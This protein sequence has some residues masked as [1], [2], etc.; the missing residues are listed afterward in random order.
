MTQES[1]L[2]TGP[3]SWVLSLEWCSEIFFVA[4]IPSAPFRRFTNIDIVV[5]MVVNC[6]N[7]S[8]DNT[9]AA[10]TFAINI[11]SLVIELDVKMRK[12]FLLIVFRIDILV[13][14]R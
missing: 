13:G 14:R 9:L 4:V 10:K 12:L 1:H 11:A 2:D 3:P 8:T 6:P 7:V 5:R